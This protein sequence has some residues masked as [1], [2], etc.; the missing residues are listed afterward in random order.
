MAN[1][2]RSSFIPKQVTQSATPKK[3]RHTRV[4]SIVGF[5]AGFLLILSLALSA[6]VFIYKGIV[7]REL[8]AQQQALASERGK[9]NEAD[10][11]EV[12]SFNERILLARSLLDGHIAPSKVFAALENS[13]KQSVRYTDFSFTRRPS[14]DVS[15]EL[16]GVTDAF[17]KVALQSL[18]NSEDFILK[19]MAVA[20]VSIESQGEEGAEGET[21]S[22]SGR[23]SIIFN[24]VSNIP[25]SKLLFESDVMPVEDNDAPATEEAVIDEVD[26]V[27]A[28][29]TVE[30]VPVVE[31]GTSTPGT[32][33]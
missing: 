30:T 11:A 22:S 25:A 23:K 10:M 14:G 7:A 32:Q 8:S 24:L 17:A 29:T 4:F 19:D 2:P 31:T 5:V 3:V 18:E 16:S 15:L 6:G 28:S 26:A 13:T 33:N 1:V 21:V 27:T 9:F 12:R 20:E